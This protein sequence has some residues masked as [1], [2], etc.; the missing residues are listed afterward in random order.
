MMSTGQD[1]PRIVGE[2]KRAL[3]AA[4]GTG[5]ASAQSLAGLEAIDWIGMLK[6]VTRENWPTIKAAID[7]FIASQPLGVRIVWRFACAA[8]EGWLKAT[9]TFTKDEID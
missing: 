4:G 7:V 3:T 8:I 2:L 6:D 9:A 1:E 5:F